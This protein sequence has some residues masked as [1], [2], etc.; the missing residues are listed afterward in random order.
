MMTKVKVLLSFIIMPEYVRVGHTEEEPT[1]YSF[2]ANIYEKVGTV[3]KYS[4]HITRVNIIQQLVSVHTVLLH[5]QVSAY[6][7]THTFLISSCYDYYARPISK[8]TQIYLFRMSAHHRNT[9]TSISE[10]QQQAPASF[11]KKAHR[12]NKTTSMS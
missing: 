1:R 4:I 11:F 10:L 3:K 2:I 5:K 6:S 9:K 8:F 12:I 7:I